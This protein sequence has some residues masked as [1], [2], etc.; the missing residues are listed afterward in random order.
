MID[1][2]RMDLNFRGT[3]LRGL[4]IFAFFAFLFSVLICASHISQRSMSGLRVESS[5]YSQA[6]TPFSATLL[7][8]LVPRRIILRIRPIPNSS[9]RSA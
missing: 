7:C 8:V 6:M 1:A 5:S 2:Y 4:R 9:V 3:K